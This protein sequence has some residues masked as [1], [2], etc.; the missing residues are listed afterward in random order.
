MIKNT[1][2]DF[3]RDGTVMQTNKGAIAGSGVHVDDFNFNQSR[4]SEVP[5]NYFEI[6][7]PTVNNSKRDGS[8]VFE[9]F[10]VE[11][12]QSEAGTMVVKS[13]DKIQK[14][15]LASSSTVVSKSKGFKF[16]QPTRAAAA[17]SKNT[18]YDD[19]MSFYS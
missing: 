16:N 11:R 15:K 9:V 10:E 19:K 6:N 13:A 17:S 5:M 2:S 18:R 12:T 14:D 4:E 8:E 1:G 7:Q 3:D